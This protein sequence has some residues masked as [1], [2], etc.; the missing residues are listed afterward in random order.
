M[1][2]AVIGAGIFG[3]ATALELRVR[4]HAVCLFEQGSVPNPHASSTDNSKVIRRDGYGRLSEYVELAERA[5]LQWARWHERIGDIYFRVGKLHVTRHFEPDSIAHLSWERFKDEPLGSRMLSRQEAGDRFPQFAYREEDVIIHDA[6][7]GYVRSGAALTGLAGIAQEEGV[8]I[9]A[10]TMVLEVAEDLRTVRIRHGGG[11]SGFDMAVVCGGPWVGR[12]VPALVEHL[13]VTR[14]EMAFFNPGDADQ[15][16][17]EITPVWSFA[18]Y[19]DGWYGLPLLHEGYVKVAMGKRV[20]EVDADV[21]RVATPEFLEEAQRFVAARLPGL[22]SGELV[23]SRACLYTNTP[24]HHFIIDRAPG[25]Q[26]TVI[27]G[28]GSGHGFKFGG[29]IGPVV[30]DVVED[31]ENPLGKLFRIGD[32]LNADAA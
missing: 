5:A 4:N 16:R 24:D 23:G 3:L 8:Q 29:S 11:T 15:Y 13:C 1:R 30:A 18:P 6:W 26:L 28:G 20:H 31:V 2:V 7:S 25:R 27:A 22:A 21:E 32:R 17:R 10:D 12:L 9:L 19:D 14:Q